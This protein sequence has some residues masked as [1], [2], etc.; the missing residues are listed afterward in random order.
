MERERGGERERESM[1]GI[2]KE[3]KMEGRRDGEMEEEEEEKEKKSS[4]L[5][6]LNSLTSAS[7]FDLERV[8]HW[9]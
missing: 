6:F 1:E 8:K 7:A 9:K 3:G 2:E 4:V 5:S